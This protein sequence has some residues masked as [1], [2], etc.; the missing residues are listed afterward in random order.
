MSLGALLLQPQKLNRF[1]NFDHAQSLGDDVMAVVRELATNAAWTEQLLQHLQDRLKDFGAEIVAQLQSRMDV[2]VSALR[3]LID[4]VIAEFQ[5]FV[6]QKPNVETVG[7]VLEL[8]VLWVK[9][10]VELIK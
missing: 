2:G 8:F 5:Q 1:A 9:N 4:P 3:L 7:D 6:M 10:A